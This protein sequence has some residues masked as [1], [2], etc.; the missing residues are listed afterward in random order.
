MAQLTHE[1][2]YS[3][4]ITTHDDLISSRAYPMDRDRAQYPELFAAATDL[5]TFTAKGVE[6]APTP[7]ELQPPEPTP[8]LQ[9]PPRSEPYRPPLHARSLTPAIIGIVHDTFPDM[10]Y[11][12]YK[13][14]ANDLTGLINAREH[15]MHQCLKQNDH[16]IEGLQNHIQ[17]LHAHIESFKRTL[18]D[19]HSHLDIHG[20]TTPGSTTA[21]CPL[22]EPFGLHHANPHR[23]TTTPPPP[24]PTL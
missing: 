2:R 19:V 4:H 5:V 21:P 16:W 22:I 17:E 7:E 10:G 1:E 11:K 3:S 24:A 12:E 20:L 23:A 9:Y 18:Q 13:G 15:E 8:A 14:L 6:Y